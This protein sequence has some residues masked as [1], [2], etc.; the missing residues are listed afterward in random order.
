MMMMMIP[1]R[2]SVTRWVGIL[3]VATAVFSLGTP[4]I[5]AQQ[6]P[7]SVIPLEPL[8]VTVLRT[9][10]LQNAAPL[11]VSV[12]TEEDL[13][14]GRSGFFLE[15]ALQ[16]M[17]GVQVQNRFNPAV[18]ERIAIRGFGGRAQ[19]G[20]R[21]IRLIVDGIPATLPDGQGSIDHLDIESLARVEAI[22]GPA[23]ALYG[24]ASGGVLVFSW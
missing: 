19:F 1:V 21:G 3:L 10:Y 24:N 5:A 13:Q 14:M 17:P 6:Q 11:A 2:A 22:R 23:S 4:E 8:E 7:D 12:L 16:G 18:G 15:E 9:P 20:L